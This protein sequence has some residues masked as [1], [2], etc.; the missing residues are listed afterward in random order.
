M[1]KSFIKAL[2][3]WPSILKSRIIF[4]FHGI[5]FPKNSRIKGKLHIVNKGSI[6]IGK[7]TLING[8]DRYN[9]IGFGSGC[10]LIAEKGAC[11][12]IGENV[13]ISNS[14]IY[15]RISVTIGNHVLIGGGVKIYDTDF[16]SLDAQYRGTP[17]DKMY[18]NNAPVLIGDNVFVGAGTIILKGVTIGDKAIIGA[19]SVVTKNI[20]SNEIWAGNP[21]KK[22][23]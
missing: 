1:I 10:N 17:E 14:T 19:G 13:G 11:I 18:T 21:A 22:I 16:H 4:F 9:P 12:K 23:K 2:L 8:R 5:S 7:N 3:L 15:S 20:P 6:M